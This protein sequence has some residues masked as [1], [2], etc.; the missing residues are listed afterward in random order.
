MI[1][2]HSFDLFKKAAGYFVL[3]CRMVM[4]KKIFKEYIF[5]N[6]ARELYNTAAKILKINNISFSFVFLFRLVSCV[7][8]AFASRNPGG[9]ELVKYKK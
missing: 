5:K 2:P 4:K 3:P 9:G 1:A 7:K 6:S 8:F